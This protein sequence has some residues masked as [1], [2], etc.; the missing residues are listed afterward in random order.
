MESLI[1]CLCD[2]EESYP[3]MSKKSVN[4]IYYRVKNLQLINKG[5]RQK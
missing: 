1:D 2:K 5:N 4:K 3:I